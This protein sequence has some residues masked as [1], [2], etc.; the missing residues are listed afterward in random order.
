MHPT[1]FVVALVL[2]VAAVSAAVGATVTTILSADRLIITDADERTRITLL[3]DP[4]SGPSILMYDES[5]RVVRRITGDASADIDRSASRPAERRWD[6]IGEITSIRQVDPDPAVRDRARQIRREARAQQLESD[7]KQREALA[8]RRMRSDDPAEVAR[9]E[10]DALEL[11]SESR[12]LAGEAKAMLREARELED[13]QAAPYQIIRVITRYGTAIVR[14]RRDMAAELEGA[15]AGQ[16]LGWDGRV[17]A[18]DADVTTYEAT[19]IGRLKSGFTPADE[20]AAD[21]PRQP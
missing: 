11:E 13:Q 6:A 1:R 18:V 15:F 2:A 12:R 14:T 10:Q 20:D 7:I 16:W 3:V 19:R 4:V 8:T 21:D 9:R 17:T 5:G